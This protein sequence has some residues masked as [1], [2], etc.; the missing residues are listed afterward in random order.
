MVA[1]SHIPPG[2]SAERDQVERFVPRKPK[3][4]SGTRTTIDVLRN[5]GRR[6]QS[7]LGSE[8]LL[9]MSNGE[10]RQVRCYVQPRSD[11]KRRHWKPG[12][13]EVSSSEVVWHGSLRKWQ[14]FTLASG[15][16]STSV[17]AVSRD[18]S[19]YRSF[20]VIECRREDEVVRLA[21][22]RGDVNLCLSSLNGQS[23]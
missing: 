18:D 12:Y 15:Q 13:L 8:D 5:I 17:R 4:A 19:V 2:I 3:R 20:R 7:E 22:P 16:W 21:I 10:R 11:E 14:S 23:Q 9:A 1:C 6:S